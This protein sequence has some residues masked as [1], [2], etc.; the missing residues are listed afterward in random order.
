MMKKDFFEQS[1]KKIVTQAEGNLKKKSTQPDSDYFKTKF[2]P[3]QAVKEWHN[4]LVK[5]NVTE[6][7]CSAKLLSKHR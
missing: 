4:K 6:N 2:N 1:G 7:L 3:I 5:D